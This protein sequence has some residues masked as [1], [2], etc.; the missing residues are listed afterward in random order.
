VATDSVWGIAM[1]RNEADIIGP[2]LA[3][4]LGQVDHV[5]IADNL[6]TDATPEI[7]AA[8]GAEVITDP[9]PAYRQSEKMTALAK[10]AR[11]GGA[12]WVVPWDADEI[13]YSPFGRIADV[14]PTL[15]LAAVAPADLYDHVPTALDPIVDNPITRIG[16]RRREPGKLAKVAC[17]TRPDLVIEQG[18]HGATY[19]RR[20]RGRRV[21]GQLVV[22]HYP[23]RTRE[24]FVAKALQGGAALKLTDLPESSGAHWRQYAQIAETHGDD[25]LAAVFDQWFHSDDPRADDTLIYDPAPV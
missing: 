12:T 6:S 19:G 23:Y 3:H 24:Q 16:W 13:W 17:R 9:D 4:M 5:L 2:V 10:R 20:W 8:S 18:N 21:S 11:D 15:D 7:L 1:V 25:A 14:L 22:R